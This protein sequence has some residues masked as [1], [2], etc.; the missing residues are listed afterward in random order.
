MHGKFG[1]TTALLYHIT[2]HARMKNVSQEP[3]CFITLRLFQ[4]RFETLCAQL[5]IHYICTWCA[6]GG[7]LA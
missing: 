7:L 5:I 3:H 6:S 1:Q 4:P 2:R